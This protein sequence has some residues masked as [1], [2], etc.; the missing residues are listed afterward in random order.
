MQNLCLSRLWGNSDF[1]KILH[2]IQRDESLL[3]CVNNIKC[4][5]QNTIV[6]FFSLPRSS[7][8]MESRDVLAL[9]MVC[10]SV[11]FTPGFILKVHVSYLHEAIVGCIFVR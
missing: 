4:F 7:G 1:I 11:N 6:N 3:V 10:W 9:W 8:G 5:A 2:L